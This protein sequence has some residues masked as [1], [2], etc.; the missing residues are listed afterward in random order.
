MVGRMSP[1]IRWT[2]RGA[3]SRNSKLLLSDLSFG[4]SWAAGV[5]SD[6]S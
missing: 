3:Q 4:D 5:M 1:S 6:K 2:S